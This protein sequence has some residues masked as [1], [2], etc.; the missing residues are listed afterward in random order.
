MSSNHITDRKNKKIKVPSL[1]NK[2]SQR[3]AVENCLDIL[4]GAHEKPVVNI[5]ISGETLK[6]FTLRS[7]TRQE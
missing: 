2:T 4:K 7:G 3:G 5:I 1:K 6:T